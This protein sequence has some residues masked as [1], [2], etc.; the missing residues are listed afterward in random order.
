MNM[1]SILAALILAVSSYSYAQEPVAVVSSNDSTA[2]KEIEVIT[3]KKHSFLTHLPAAPSDTLPD[4]YV[5]PDGKRRMKNY[6]NSIVGPV[7]LIQYVATPALLTARNSPSEWGSKW[8]GYG[9]RVANVVGKNLI[10]NTTTYALDEA[11]KVDSSFYQSKDRSITAR[12]RNAAFSSVTARDKN[13]KRVVGVPRIAG[14]F[15]SEVLSSVA[16]YPPRYDY[17]HGLKGGAISLG[18]NAGFNLIR[19]FIYKK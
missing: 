5:R 3:V 17:V 10:R 14:S 12:L 18:I 8:P 4:P 15:L 2:M 19:E 6:I 1:R 9:R 13:G 11:L 7:A 16:W